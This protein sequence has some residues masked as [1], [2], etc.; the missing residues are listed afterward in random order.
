MLEEN[1]NLEFG[2]LVLATLN[3]NDTYGYMLTQQIKKIISLSESALYPTLRQLQSKKFVTTYDREYNG[4]NRRYYSITQSGKDE[5]Q[6]RI[7]NW[8]IYKAQVEKILRGEIYD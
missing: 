3:K 5:L 6:K 1:D 2:T 8:N 4:R 7:D